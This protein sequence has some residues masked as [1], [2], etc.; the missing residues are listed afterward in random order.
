MRK[1][2]FQFV[3]VIACVLAFLQGGPAEAEKRVALVIGNAAYAHTS[4][5]RNPAHDARAIADLLGKAGFDKVTLK[6]DLGYDGMRLALR[7]FGLVTRGADVALV[8]F[9]GHGLEF[10]GENYLV[11][12]DAALK[13]DSSVSFETATLSAVLEAIRPA[14]R[15]RLVILDACRN[16]PLAARMEPTGGRTRSISRGLGRIEPTGDVLVAY[17]AKAG[18]VAED[19]KGRHSPYA[20]ALLSTLSTPGLDIRLVLGRVRDLVVAKTN[21]AQE[22]FVYGSLGGTTVALIAP[23]ADAAAPRPDDA[24][25]KVQRDYDMAAKIGSKEAWDAFLATHPRGYQADLARAQRSKLATPAPMPAPAP[26]PP[27]GPPA[28]APSPPA[29]DALLADLQ[30]D[31]EI[32]RLIETNPTFADA[33]PVTAASYRVDGRFRST[34]GTGSPTDMSTVSKMTVRA[35]RPGLARLE[36]DYAFTPKEPKTTINMKRSTLLAAN[37]LILVVE[38]ERGAGATTLER[39]TRISNMKGKIY[40]VAVGNRFSYATAHR[41]SAGGFAYTWSTA[42]SC[43]VTRKLNAGAFHADLAG[44]AY[45]AEC[46]TR[47]NDSEGTS[48]TAKEP[49]IFFEALG[50]WL[51]VDSPSSKEAL[52][53]TGHSTSSKLPG[54]E[55]HTTSRNLLKAFT[56]AR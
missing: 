44:S 37:G 15:L 48:A 33:P 42:T 12:V 32:L 52:V 46:D 3:A 54:Q 49:R 39:P 31:T 17:A 53:S 41:R 35:I 18:T 51:Q 38:R 8:Y 19:G 13:S 16:N 20:E 29:P 27:P 5:L 50:L 23:T 34:G 24:D 30:P 28:A 7:D 2:T 45:V 14:A 25:A 9:A 36:T 43:R 47:M 6:V 1:R 11:P 55:F 26:L 22:P 4:T 56:L 40:P 21:G 10:G